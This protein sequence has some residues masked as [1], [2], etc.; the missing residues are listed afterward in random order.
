MTDSTAPTA[1]DSTAHDSTARPPRT[2]VETEVPPDREAPRCE[3]CGRPFAAAP[4]LA[5]HRGLA[6][7]DDLDP[8]EREAYAAA[9]D[10]E[11]ADLRRFRIVALGALVLLYF[12]LLFAYAVFA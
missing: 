1:P 11:R 8:A 2:A 7:G 9:L 12:G 10:D 6:H 3:R 5:L 4:A